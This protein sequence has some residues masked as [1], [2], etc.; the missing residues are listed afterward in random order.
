MLARLMKDFETT[1]ATLATRL[2]GAT[3]VVLGD[4]VA[5][6]Y[7]FGETDR[8]SRE[9]PVPIVRWESVQTRPGGAANVAANVAALGARVR[10]VGLVGQDTAGR[11]LLAAFEEGGADAGH[12][13]S[14]RDRCTETKTRILAG[15]RSTT[16]QQMLR[17]DRADERP[18]TPRQ[19]SRL[20][21]AFE[22]ACRGADVIV[23]SD[24]GAGLVDEPMADS[25]RKLARRKPVCV[26]SR[27]DL[28]RF[29]GVTVAK[30]NE[31]ELEAVAGRRLRTTE[32][33]EA[34][35][36]ALREQ[37]D[38]EALVVTRGRHG[39]EIFVE[40]AI[41]HLPVW[42]PAEAVDVTG[43]G[44]TVLATLACAM[45]TGADVITSARLANVAGGLVVQKAG[46]ATCS[47][48]ELVQALAPTSRRRA[49]ARR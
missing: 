18:I 40:G 23:V 13:V 20:R 3:V 10:P 9:A 30:P 49:G 36:R 39:M 21:A 22:A 34:A 44:D 38:V 26:D 7:V 27:Y 12:V 6:E 5:D 29:T 16:R 41:E 32:D 31:P 45:G 37:L 8:V 2:S 14:L 46:T 15:G 48:D 28:S 43:A 11:R 35:G 24:Y 42:G 1:L 17:V 33:V 47:A 4:L 25:L 19:R